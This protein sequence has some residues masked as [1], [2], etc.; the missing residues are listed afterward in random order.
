MPVDPRTVFLTGCASGIGRDLADA[1]LSAGHRIWATDVAIDRLREH[2]RSRAWPAERSACAHLDVRDA[3]AWESTYA[4]AIEQLGGVDVHI[5]VAGY[6]RPGWLRALPLEELDRHIDVNLRGV[7]YG[8]AV[9]AR[10]MSERRRGHIINIASLAGI[11]PIPGIAIYSATKHAVRGLSLAAAAELR[12]HGVAV[13]TICPDAVETPML[14]L[15]VDHEEAALT[16]SGARPLT[17]AQVV[18]AVLR[19]LDR[20]PLEVAMPRSR[21]VLARLAALFPASV[22]LLRGRL[23]RRGASRQAARPRTTRAG[24]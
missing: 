19:A 22:Q 10:H 18:A 13:T 6:L 24:V 11:A 21:A 4:A 20:R 17:T 15:Q 23:A 12:E 16:F 2:A 3:A 9:A 14:E 7:A 5:N 8:T 1:L